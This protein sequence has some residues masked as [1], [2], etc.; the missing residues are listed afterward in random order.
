MP[1]GPMR[2]FDHTDYDNS[3]TQIVA[4]KPVAMA[5]GEDTDRAVGS[6]P[7]LDA[8]YTVYPIQ[9]AFLDPVL[10]I[11]K[12]ATSTVVP[13]PEATSPTPSA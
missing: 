7:I 11:D 10:T 9:Q 5:W 4:N 8:G 13:W 12:A 6:D 1:C 2:I 3:G